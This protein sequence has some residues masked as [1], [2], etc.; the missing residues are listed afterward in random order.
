MGR[1]IWLAAAI[2]RKSSALRKSTART[3]KE[4]VLV[5]SWLLE[6]S[7]AY[8]LHLIRIGP[9]KEGRSAP[10]VRH[11]YNLASTKYELISKNASDSLPERGIGSFPA[12]LLILLQVSERPGCSSVRQ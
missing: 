10:I 3:N 11:V 6:N 4:L 2:L 5:G 7:S 8:G 12:R 1:P 9:V